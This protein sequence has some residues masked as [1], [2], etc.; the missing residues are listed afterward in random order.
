MDFITH[1]PEIQVGYS[2]LD[3]V[4][5]V[6]CKLTKMVHLIPL[7]T[8]ATASDVAKLFFTNI[9]RLHGLPL[10]IISDRD[11]KFTSSFWK[12]LFQCFNTQLMFSSAYHPQTDGQSE[13]TN[14]T[15]SQLIRTFIGLEESRWCDALPHIE[16]V[17]NNAVNSSSGFSPFF[18]N[19]TYHPYTPLSLVTPE[20]SIKNAL[21][22][23]TVIQFHHNISLAK[24]LLEQAAAYQAKYAN[25]KRRD[26]NFDVGDS[27]MLATKHIRLKINAKIKP[28]WI[29]PFQIVRKISDVVFKLQ[30]PN[31]LTIH[32]VFHAC[33]L[34]PATAND[35][36]PDQDT[37]E[38][39]PEPEP[40]PSQPVIDSNLLEV[41]E[42]GQELFEVEQIL[43]HRTRRGK[44][45][46]LVKWAG[47]SDDENSWEP[48]EGLSAAH[49]LVEQYESRLR[50][51]L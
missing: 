4:L 40:D 46:Y 7:H 5:T 39:E 41:D 36:R 29:G 32:D 11:A 16:F 42:S 6:T 17:I 26:I 47:C 25:Q 30:L 38:D 37:S 35:P 21:A 2:K 19:Y 14:R 43:N 12:S 51:S 45:E 44:Y 23:T 48:I 22:S 10:L 15:V 8:T 33:V 9:V 20:P 50:G 28:K 31:N 34:K 3:S 24:D 27:V 18:A 1:L 13:R 49:D